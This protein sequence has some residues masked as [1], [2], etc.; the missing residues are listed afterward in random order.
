MQAQGDYLHF[1][2]AEPAGID[3]TGPEVVGALINAAIK[4]AIVGPG[5]GFCAHM[6]KSSQPKAMQYLRAGPAHADR[7]G[8][9]PVVVLANFIMGLATLGLG[10]APTYWLAVA[11]RAL[12]GAANG[13]GVAIKTMLA[14]ACDAQSQAHGMVGMPPAQI[15]RSMPLDARLC[16]SH[17]NLAESYNGC[18]PVCRYYRRLHGALILEVCLGK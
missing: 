2:R 18:A 15:A 13:S 16:A 7:I 8:R 1:S 14:E 17:F 11:A 4:L 6:S 10:L 12:G 5:P 3:I 9:K